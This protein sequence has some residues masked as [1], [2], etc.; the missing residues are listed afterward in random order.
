[1]FIEAINH[2]RNEVDQT[3]RELAGR[4][5]NLAAKLDQLVGETFNRPYMDPDSL[6][7]LENAARVFARLPDYAPMLSDS[8][9]RLSGMPDYFHTLHEAAEMLKGLPSTAESVRNAAD[10]VEQAGMREVAAGA[11]G[12]RTAASELS[13]AVGQTYALGETAKAIQQAA[14]TLKAATK[15]LKETGVWPDAEEVAAAE[16]EA[17]RQKLKRRLWKWL[18][19]GAVAAF[20]GAVAIAIAAAVITVRVNR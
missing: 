6:E 17:A 11:E 3:I 5:A 12:L 20:V 10:A 19:T 7:I 16:D 18:A 1:M 9:S 4:D 2:T 13:V 14:Q 15:E 8:A